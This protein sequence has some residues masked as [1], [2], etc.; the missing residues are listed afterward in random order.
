MTEKMR[1]YFKILYV[2]LYIYRHSDIGHLQNDV[3]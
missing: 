3:F 1:M 2:Y